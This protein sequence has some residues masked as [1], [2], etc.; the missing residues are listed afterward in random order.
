MDGSEFVLVNWSSVYVTCKL[1][2][3]CVDNSVWSLR[4][5]IGTVPDLVNKFIIHFFQSN[6]T[7]TQRFCHCFPCC[8]KYMTGEENSFK[9]LFIYS[10]TSKI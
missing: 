9:V 3:Q 1:H 2:R 7:F 5:A 8:C 4:P 6:S 10:K